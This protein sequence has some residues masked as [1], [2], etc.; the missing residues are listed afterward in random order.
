MSPTKGGLVEVF[1]FPVLPL[2]MAIGTKSEPGK[3]VGSA[4]F[5][6]GSLFFNCLASLRLAEGTAKATEA[7][8]ALDV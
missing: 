6:V 7:I 4:Q 2:P 5:L 8:S 1:P 3:E